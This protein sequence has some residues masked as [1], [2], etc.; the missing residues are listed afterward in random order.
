MKSHCLI[1]GT[2]RAGTTFLVQLFTRLGL[3]TGFSEETLTVD[4]IANAGLERCNI[5]D[6]SPY[7]LKSPWFCDTIEKIVLANVIDCVIIPMRN[8]KDAAASRIRVQ[9]NHGPEKRKTPVPGGLW[10]TYD[11]DE[12]EK[13]LAIQ[14]TRLVQ[15]LIAHEIPMFFLHFPRF[16]QDAMYLYQKVKFLMPHRSFEEFVTIFK[17]TVKPELIHSFFYQQDVGIGT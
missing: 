15:T 12:Q 14:F 7:I 17:L 5:T 10:H 16:A 1:S 4:K 13:I 6:K 2:G 8:L 9:N 11:P 3:D